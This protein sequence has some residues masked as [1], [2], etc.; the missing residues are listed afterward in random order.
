MKHT[1]KWLVDASTV[2]GTVASEPAGNKMG[3]ITGSYKPTVAG[4]YKLRM[5]VTDQYKVTSYATTSGDY[6]AY[7]V[8]YDPKGGYTYGTGTFTSPAGALPGN[9]TLSDKVTFG[10]TSNYY[11]GATNPKGETEFDFILTDGNY[12]F[13]FNALNYDYLVVTGAK[14]QYK[15]LGKTTINGVDQA[16]LAFILTVVDGQVA[17]GGG[18][19]KIRMKIYNKNT[20][21]VIYDNQPGAG[22][23]ASPI[24][25]ADDPINSIVIVN[26][27]SKSAEITQDVLQDNIKPTLRVY[28]NPFSEKLRF[29]F[30]SPL[31]TNARIDIYD[32]TG[33]L[34]T[35]L[36]DK[37]V[38][39]GVEYTVDF[40]PDVIVSGMYLYRVI[41]GDQVLTD[42]VLF[43][44]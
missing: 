43:A 22:D 41:L 34:V 26:V 2:N 16:G 11:K 37:P 12:T 27:P 24:M 8:A 5:N 44:K 1:A 28:P 19:D 25:A 23:T 14:A 35:T 36:F 21:V 31:N 32:I 33:R 3:R 20:G 4:I 7:F 39:A 40:R 15:G 17:G 6:E 13:G 18:I 29:E 38:E 30:I 42:K 9:P 10:F